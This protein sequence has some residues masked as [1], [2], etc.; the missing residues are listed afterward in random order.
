MTPPAAAHNAAMT[1]SKILLVP[2]PDATRTPGVRRY[3][4]ARLA[5]NPPARAAR[6]GFDHLKRTYD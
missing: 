3:R 6:E 4:L 2:A 5:V 1:S